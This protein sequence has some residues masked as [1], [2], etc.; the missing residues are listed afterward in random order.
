MELEEKEPGEMIK[1]MLKEK[2]IDTIRDIEII[3]IPLM[4]V[5]FLLIFL[6]FEAAINQTENVVTNTIEEEKP[7]QEEAKVEETPATE[8]VVEAGE[9]KK[10]RKKDKKKKDGEEETE[11]KKDEILVDEN[12]VSYD[13]YKILQ[14]Q[15]LEKL[16][17]ERKPEVKVDRP[18]VDSSLKSMAQEEEIIGLGKKNTGPQQK[19]KPKVEEKHLAVGKL[20]L[21]N[22]QI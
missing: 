14:K 7:K 1:I 16:N 13:E 3:I 17:Q 2:L 18:V 11:K 6:D 22:L 4:I 9:E 19:A 8:A 5:Q 12:S 20:K 15:K 10:Y 21:I